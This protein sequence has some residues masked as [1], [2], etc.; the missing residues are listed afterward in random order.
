[1]KKLF[2]IVLCLCLLFCCC[3]SVT[4]TDMRK[5]IAAA[6]AL[7]ELG[8]FSGTGTDADGKPI[9]SLEKALT[10]QEAIA[11]LVALLGKSGE[12]RAETWEIPFTDVDG[13]ALPY[14]GY[15][16]ANGLTSGVSATRFG[17]QD[18][19][20]AA[21]YLTFLLG[22]L[23]YRNGTDFT[24]SSSWELTDQLEIT[25]GEYGQANNNQFI[26]AD[27]VIV[28]YNA[29]FADK[30]EGGRLVE[31]MGENVLDK[32]RPADSIEWSSV[33]DYPDPVPRESNPKQL[34][35]HNIYSDPVLTNQSG[36]YSG[37]LID[38]RADYT[39]E[40]TYWALCNW[41]MD[42]SCL[43]KLGTVTDAG[44]AY[45]GLQSNDVGPESIMSFWEI[46]Y[47]DSKGSKHVINANRVYPETNS[48]NHFGGEGEGTNYITGYEWKPGKW[49]R[50]YIGC[51]EDAA[52]GHTFVEQWFEDIAKKKWTKICVFDTGLS[53]SYFKG[54]MSQFMENYDYETSN[55]VRTFEYKNIYVRDYKTGKWNGITKSTLSIDTWWG[56]KK[57]SYAFGANENALYGITC[58]YGADTAPLNAD[59]RKTFTIKLTD[60]PATPY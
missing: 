29:L 34:M 25:E 38:F 9:Y 16:Y 28:S 8:L 14:V 55:N 27:V 45:A 41:D 3:S 15:A 18:R 30:K 33:L 56:N 11:L 48:T 36:K 20:S 21:Q 13:W 4:A 49:Y 12:A 53:N 6:D 24:W 35:A 37:F 52:S 60:D 22:A 51:Y 44:G 40:G 10:R 50:M 7:H 46:T 39:P 59:I 42:T 19:V 5:A 17:A 2:S 23:G 43:S 58:G 54:A 32:I 1:M 31:G 47:K 57:G 26:R